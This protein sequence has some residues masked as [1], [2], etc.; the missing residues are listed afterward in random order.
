MDLRK[1]ARGEECMVRVPGICNHNQE[2]T[3]LAHFRQSAGMGRKPHDFI[4][5]WACSACHDWVD[6]RTHQH[7][8]QATKRTMFADAVIRTQ[9]RLLDDGEVEI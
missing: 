9:Q 5:A 4:G 8:N 6:N 2:T 7:E 3:V 1:R